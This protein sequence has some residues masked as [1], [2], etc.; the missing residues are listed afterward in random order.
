MLQP[1][2]S[3]R[4]LQ[5][6]INMH[7]LVFCNFLCRFDHEIHSTHLYAIVAIAIYLYI[8]GDTCDRLVKH[9]KLLCS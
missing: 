9:F 7:G 5:K 8:E 1:I 2:G 6:V 3:V 4:F